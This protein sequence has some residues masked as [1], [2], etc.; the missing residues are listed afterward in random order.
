MLLRA[1]PTAAAARRAL[2]APRV[3]AAAKSTSPFAPP[4]SSEPPPA[5]A[6]GGRLSKEEEQQQR[7]RMVAEA[8]REKT[9]REVSSA[10]AAR[11]PEGVTHLLVN[12]DSALAEATA[13]MDGGEAATKLA[14]TMDAARAAGVHVVGSKWLEEVTAQCHAASAVADASRC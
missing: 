4:P 1:R 7:I 8:M 12:D 13:A 5:S 11:R 14:A 9:M 6:G 2:L 10:A 3:W